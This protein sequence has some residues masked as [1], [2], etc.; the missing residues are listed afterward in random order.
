MGTDTHT[1]IQTGKSA[2]TLGGNQVV[3]YTR[4][5]LLYYFDYF[6]CSTV[7]LRLLPLLYCTTSTHSPSLVFPPLG[8]A[9]AH[10]P[11]TLPYL[12]LP[13]RQKSQKSQKS[14][15]SQKSQK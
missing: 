5:V 12:T 8:P 4:F 13:Y 7:L 1:Y 3:R 11:L 9:S 14:Q 2:S 6:L 15:R 10:P